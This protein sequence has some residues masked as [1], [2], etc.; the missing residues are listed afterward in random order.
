MGTRQGQLSVYFVEGPRRSLLFAKRY[1]LLA[2]FWLQQA[3]LDVVVCSI[4][5]YVTA[6]NEIMKD[7][8]V[9]LRC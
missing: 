4:D 9:F 5:D 2:S 7:R 6:K 8:K 3:M 1:L